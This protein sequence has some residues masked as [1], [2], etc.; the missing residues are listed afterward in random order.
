MRAIEI[1]L[2]YRA[3]AVVTGGDLY[4]NSIALFIQS[5]DLFVPSITRYP[6]VCSLLQDCGLETGNKLREILDVQ[7]RKSYLF[8]SLLMYLPLSKSIRTSKLRRKTN[9]VFSVHAVV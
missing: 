5:L 9:P 1:F 6:L 4:G 7:L 2:P 8:F 3:S